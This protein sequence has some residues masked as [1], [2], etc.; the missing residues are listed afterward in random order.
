MTD[1]LNPTPNNDGNIIKSE[2]LRAYLYRVC[3]SVV[4]LATAYGII[5]D[6]KAG[7]YI[8]VAA[9]VLGLP[10]ATANTSTKG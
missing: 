10:V 9:A 6:Q 1:N 7:L 8:A 4:T 2:K 5:A 3:G